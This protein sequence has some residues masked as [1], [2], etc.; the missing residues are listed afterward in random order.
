MSAALRGGNQVHIA[1]GRDFA[2]LGQPLHG[3]VHGFVIALHGAGEGLLGQHGPA[4][5]GLGQIIGEAVLEI[6]LLALALVAL[7]G[8][9]DETHAQAR[10]QHRLGAQHM[11][12]AGDVD[13]GSIEVFLVGHEAHRGARHALGRRADGLKFGSLLA[14]AKAHLVERAVATHQHLEI[15]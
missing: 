9:V 13:L 12:E 4:L 6:P 11:L 1:F 14:V 15:A 10:A 5:S 7:G 2:A 8:V 3:P